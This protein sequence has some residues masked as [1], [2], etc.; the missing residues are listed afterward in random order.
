MASMRF[1]FLDSD[2]EDF[3]HTQ[4]LR[5]LDEV[6]IQV[7]SPPIQKM[8][9]DAGADVDRKTG[10]IRIPEALVDEALERAPKSFTLYSRN[11]K[12]NMRLPVDDCPYVGT[13][14]LAIHMIDRE[15]GM[16][17]PATRKDAVDFAR[18]GDALDPVDFL[19][20]TIIP[21]DVPEESHTAHELWISLI[22][23]SKHLQQVE[24]RN[25][26]D[27]KMQIK[28]ASLIVGGADELKKR[29]I[30]SVVVSPDSPLVFRK[31][32]IEGQV[33]LAR[34]GIPI[35]SMDMPLSG[36]T[37]PVTIAGTIVIVNSENLASLVITQLAAPG[38]P[39][40]YSSDAVPGDMA[41]GDVGY[42]AIEV[43][44]IFS[45]LGQ[46]AKRYGLPSMVGDWGLGGE[47]CPGMHNSYSEISSTTLDT[48]SGTDLLSG[49]GST[50]KA[51]GAS[52]EQMVVDA[53]LWKNWK[54]FLRK[55]TINEETAALDVIKSVGHG[56]IFLTNPHT[57]KNFRKELRLRDKSIVS[58]ETDPINRMVP[59]AK[60]I[61]T[62]LL[63]EH[64]PEPVDKS[65][66]KE[67]G[68][69]IM[70][71]ERMLRKSI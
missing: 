26:D 52:L 9:S 15:T 43:P 7:R 68:E 62:K 71:Y 70:N 53:F 66:L 25:S 46:M 17:R 2:E 12:Y 45:A 69:L 14:G 59:E 33:E 30:F 54:G 31:D 4:S 1:K 29:P 55:M 32:A 63:K 5:C 61:V 56:N 10:V 20:S 42:G 47:S 16:R 24:C 40:I 50:D 18:L 21:R 51:K 37:A 22:N 38:S 67:G 49:I 34:A 65:I 27:A 36:I 64:I 19:W 3:V 57:I 39:Q 35:V 44:M 41:S 6:G 28:L 48:F 60:A 8:L 11:P 23:S 13:T 58:W